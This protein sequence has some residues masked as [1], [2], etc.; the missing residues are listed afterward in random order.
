MNRMRLGVVSVNYRRPDLLLGAINSLET[1]HDH[2]FFIVDRATLGA[3]V[4]SLSAAWNRGIEAALA[5][6]A[7][8]V[9]V[10]CDDVLFH[11]CTVDHLVERAQD[12]GYGFLSAY[13]V[14]TRLHLGP[15]DLA[16]L[17]VPEDGL[18]EQAADYSCFLLSAGLFREIGPF[19]EAFVPAYFEDTDYNLRLGL[20]GKPGMLTAYAPYFHY[21]GASGGIAPEIAQRNRDYFVAKWKGV[22]PWAEAFASTGGLLEAPGQEPG[23]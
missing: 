23:A 7:Q 17:P 15:R 19:D 8:W 4:P 18:D 14:Q 10:T 6:R 9:L 13:E 16:A 22:V 11:P 1:T 21:G 5:W 12:R 3:E 20:A 2:K